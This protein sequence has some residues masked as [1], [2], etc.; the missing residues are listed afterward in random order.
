MT[1]EE[2][3]QRAKTANISGYQ[4][5][6]DIGLS[7]AIAYNFM[8]GDTKKLRDANLKKILDYVQQREERGD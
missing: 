2:L 7:K 8:N 5:H 3:R 4:L 6:R 1:T